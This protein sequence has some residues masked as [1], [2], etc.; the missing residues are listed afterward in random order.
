[1]KPEE[2]AR[3]EA[4]EQQMREHSHNGFLGAEIDIRNMRGLY[5]TVTVAADLT[6]LLAGKPVRIFDQILIDTTTGTKKLYI[7][8]GVGAVWRSCTIS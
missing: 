6:R 4:L 1:M 2:L 8:D 5:K 3:V 7:Y